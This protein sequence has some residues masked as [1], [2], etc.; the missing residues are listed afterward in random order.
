MRDALLSSMSLV[1]WLIAGLD[2]YFCYLFFKAYKK[3][4][5]T[6]VLLMALIALGL[7]YDAVVLG[8][9]TILE[10]G[11]LLS[12]LSRPRFILHGISVPLILPICGYAL[13]LDKKWMKVVWIITG[14]VLVLGLLQGILCTLDY[15]EIGGLLR[16]YR[17]KTAKWMDIVDS[18]LSFGMIIPLLIV[19]IIVVV[20][21]KIPA[22]LL[23]GVMMFAF[24]ALAPATGNAD[25]IFYVSM[26]GELLMIY[27]FYLFQ[28][29]FE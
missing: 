16:M 13:R 12:V 8:L 11:T 1:I 3:E 6:M 9:G 28:R 27:Y 15:K 22:L 29:R 19:G 26:I 5:R 17:V 4:K 23:S 24:S 2:G 21:E 7:T 20:K 14:A 18:L 25:L 10:E